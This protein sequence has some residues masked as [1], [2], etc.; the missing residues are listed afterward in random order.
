MAH[1]PKCPLAAARMSPTLRWCSE[2]RMA[3]LAR[4]H[5][6]S[7]AFNCGDPTGSPDSPASPPQERKKPLTPL[8]RCWGALSATTAILPNLRRISRRYGTSKGEANAS[9]VR[10]NCD[11]SSETGPNATNF[12]WLPACATWILSPTGNQCFVAFPESPTKIASSCTNTA[13]P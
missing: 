6:S 5:T 3:S 12:W 8:A 2:S 7:M 1:P 11:P 9:R 4:R 13:C 10:K